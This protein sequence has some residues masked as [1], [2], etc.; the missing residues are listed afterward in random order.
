[1]SQFPYSQS[2]AYN[3]GS[4]TPQGSNV[5][6]PVYGQAYQDNEARYN[7]IL[8]GY[9]Q[10]LSAFNQGTT[11]I[12]AGYAGMAHAAQGLGQTQQMDIQN[13]YARQ[14][15]NNQQSLMARGLGNSSVLD[16]AQRGNAYDQQMAQLHAQDQTL[17]NVQGIQGQALGYQQQAQAQAAGLHG[18]QLNYMGSMTNRPQNPVQSVSYG[19]PQGGTQGGQVMNYNGGYGGGGQQGGSFYQNLGAGGMQQYGYGPGGG[20]YPIGNAIG[21]G[22]QSRGYQGSQEDYSDDYGYGE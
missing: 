9:Q 16:S 2:I 22:G 6:A 17:Q 8:G 18:Q 11:G 13:N 12:N 20:S 7:Q 15:A 5:V 3:S 21:G 4:M 19:P 14:G 10:Q 1:M